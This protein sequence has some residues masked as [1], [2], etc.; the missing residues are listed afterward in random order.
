MSRVTSQATIDALASDSIRLATLIKLNFPTPYYITDYGQ[1]LSY[2]GNSYQASSYILGIGDAAETGGIKVNSMDITFSAVES[3]FT[4]LFLTSNYVNV[5]VLVE[6]VALDDND[7]VIGESIAF[8]DGRIVSF[9]IEDSG[10]DS[11]I[12]IE[13]ASHWQDFD[14][15][16]NRKTNS[17][18]QNFW[19]PEDMGFEFAA[20]TITDLKWGRK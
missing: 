9:D 16:Q 5:Q 15:V 8:F 6:R 4:A 13:M 17:K 2:D 12:T 18:S 14:K 7:N 19:Y 10:S 3:N 1:N 20:S 11:E